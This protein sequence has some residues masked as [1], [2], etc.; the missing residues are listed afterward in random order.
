MKISWHGHS[1]VQ[2]RTIGNHR[3]IID[4]FIRGNDLSDL[5]V[6]SLRVDTI[7]L[8]HAHADHVGDTIEIAKK[9]NADVIAIVELADEL[10][11]HGI[12]AHGM[13]IGG[14]H[15][16]A[17][18]SVK[19]VPAIHSSS[20]EGREMGLAAGVIV[21]DEIST[22]YHCGDTALFSDMQLIPHTNA[23][24]IPIGDNYTMGINDAVK[25]ATYIDS[26][27]FIPIHYDTFPIIEQNPYE[28]TNKLPLVN[29]LVPDIGEEIEL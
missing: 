29:G 24:F 10:R 17:F 28:F 15:A 3:I 4:P 2:I 7:I 23:C 20:Y 22:I 25:A 26:D 11:K 21:N 13:N 18:G 19:F 5:D 9:T 14:E 8:T 1:C 6:N 12:S 16:F 27:L